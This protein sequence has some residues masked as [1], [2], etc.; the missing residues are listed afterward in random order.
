M[1]DYL[2]YLNNPQIVADFQKVFGL[3]WEFDENN[4]NIKSIL[5]NSVK[6]TNTD[7]NNNLSASKSTS[8]TESTI[9]KRG[10]AKTNSVVTDTD[11]SHI[12]SKTVI[13]NKFW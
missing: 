6:N 12:V 8:V 2:H 9:F 7:N 5:K 3:E 11:H 10:H 1:H 13:N 4:N